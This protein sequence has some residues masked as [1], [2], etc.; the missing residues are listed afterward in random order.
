MGQA[1]CE[2][3]STLTMTLDSLQSIA[4]LAV[5]LLLPALYLGLAKA[6]T[7]DAPQKRSTSPTSE[8]LKRKR[9][10]EFEARAEAK[11][12]EAARKQAYDVVSRDGG[13]MIGAVGTAR[14]ERFD[15]RRKGVLHFHDFK[16]C[17]I[18]LSAFVGG[19]GGAVERAALPTLLGTAVDAELVGEE[20][21]LEAAITAVA[22]NSADGSHGR[23]L[24]LYRRAR[25][26]AVEVFFQRAVTT[27]SKTTLDRREAR[28]ELL[29][30]LCWRETRKE[31][32][33]ASVDE[34]EPSALRQRADAAPPQVTRLVFCLCVVPPP[35]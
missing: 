10:A 32:E 4:A 11:R 12:A 27:P 31:P 8:D 2:L 29:A 3:S 28:R 16:L 9:F 17:G 23:L 33:R 34:R 13:F 35:L 26:V 7:P 25:R 22:T 19:D 15:A 5:L 1:I 14:V 6:R 20:R 30:G 21:T 18:W 24:A